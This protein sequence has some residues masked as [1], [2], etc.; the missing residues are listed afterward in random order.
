MDSFKTGKVNAKQLYVRSGPNK[1]YGPI[2]EMPIITEGTKVDILQHQKD[3]QDNLW[4]AIMI[5]D[6]ISGY[7]MAKYINIE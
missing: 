3:S 6:S 7:V 5:N 4:F 1:D 2:E